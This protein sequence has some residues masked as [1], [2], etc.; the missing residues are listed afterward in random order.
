MY[1][2]IVIHLPEDSHMS[3]RSMQ[4]MYH[5]Y[6]ILSRIYVHL[7]ILAVRLKNSKPVFCLLSILHFTLQI[8]DLSNSV[9]CSHVP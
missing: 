2:S 7:L 5:A 4:E 6:N 9:Y 3:G 1:P 8:C